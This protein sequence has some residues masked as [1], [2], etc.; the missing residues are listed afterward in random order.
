M[1]KLSN[2]SNLEIS[3]DIIKSDYFIPDIDNIV[4]DEDFDC[5]IASVKT[6]IRNAKY[7]LKKLEEKI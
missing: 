7:L 2:K 6:R 4:K 5:I 3:L 1:L